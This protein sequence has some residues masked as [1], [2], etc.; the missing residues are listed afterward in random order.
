MQNCC[1]Y[2]NFPANCRVGGE[3]F[4]S[5]KRKTLFHLKLFGGNCR[6][7]SLFFSVFIILLFFSLKMPF[8]NIEWVILL[9]KGAQ[10][11]KLTF[12]P[13]VHTH[14]QGSGASSVRLHCLSILGEG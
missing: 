4:P 9:T 2:C 6:Y 12:Y 14:R 11:V 3:Y 1:N 10:E 5:A 8:L 13:A 7:F